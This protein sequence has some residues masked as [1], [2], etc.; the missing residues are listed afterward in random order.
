MDENKVEGGAGAALAAHSKDAS[1]PGATPASSATG[2]DQEAP[3]TIFETASRLAG[4]V[5][6]SISD[7]AGTG[8]KDL[9]DMSGRVA[10]QAAEFVRER[11]FAALVITGV[12]CLMMGVLL[13]RR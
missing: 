2:N 4:Q 8:R 13:G 9:P 1:A 10:D 5:G 3:G 6:S 12:V 11:P 7:M